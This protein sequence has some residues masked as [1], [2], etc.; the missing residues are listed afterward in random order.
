MTTLHNPYVGPRA[1]EP[2]DRAN[3]FGRDAEIRQLTDLVVAQRAVLLYARSGAGKTSLINAGLIPALERRRMTVL[4]VAR[5]GGGAPSAAPNPFVYNVLA[6][7]AAETVTPEAWLDLTLHEGL[8]PDA[9]LFAT[10]HSGVRL[11]ILDQFEELFTL[12]PDQRAAREAFFAQLQD[13]LDAYPHL[14]VLLAMREEYLAYLDTFSAML[15]DRL[16]TRFRLELLDPEAARLAIQAPAREQGVTFTDAAADQLVDDLRQMRTQR[17]DGTTTQHTGP[18][19]EPVQL[20]VVCRQIWA[21]TLGEND[22][23]TTIVASDL[24]AVG[25]VDKALATYYAQSV[26]RIAAETDV[27]ERAIRAWCEQHLITP[28]G[29]RGIVLRGTG[30]APA[31]VTRLEDAHLIRAEKR[32]GA[33]WYELAHDRLVGPVR[34]DNAAWFEANLSLLQRQAALWAEQ[35]RPAGLLLSDDVLVKATTWAEEHADEMLETEREF[36]AASRAEQERVKRERTQHRRIRWLAVGTTLLMLLACV[37]ACVTIWQ[38]QEVGEAILDAEYQSRISRAQALAALSQSHDDPTGSLNLMLAR[39]AA[40]TTWVTDTRIIERSF[41]TN[42][43]LTALNL[44]VNRAQQ[45]PWRMTIPWRVGHTDAVHAVAYSPDGNYI[46]SGSEDQTV[47]I[48]DAT[49]G[50]ELMQLTGHTG[51]IW[52]VAYSPD[53]TRIV[54]GGADQTVRIWDAAS[55][56]ELQ[57]L[58]GH[59]D[60][61]W[62]VAYSPDGERIVSGSADETVRV[63][64]AQ[65]GEEIQQ[66]TGHTDWVWAVAYSPDGERIVSGS[67]DETVRVWDAQ[68]GKEILE[69]IGHSGSVSTVGYSPDGTRIISG[70]GH[71]YEPENYATDDTVRIWDA[72]TGEELQQLTEKTGDLTAVTYSPDGIHILSG[73]WDGTAKI[74]D[75]ETG[76]KELELTHAGSVYAVVYSPDG[77]KIVSGSLDHTVRVWDAQTGAEVQS[78]VAA[79]PSTGHTDYVMAVAYSPDGERMVGGLSA[80]VKMGQCGSGIRKVAKDCSG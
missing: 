26:A 60:W 18:H 3:F 13:A 43:A 20:Q 49:S 45:L 74:W 4:P 27:R 23:R 48:W 14:G 29:L 77:T 42:E 70:G 46:V 38:I 41:V 67:A 63:W 52:S 61:V 53:G 80:G 51:G 25:D 22:T 76:E 5:V 24:E 34:E 66:L 8:A 37:L 78:G 28:Q 54:S 12:H 1:F 17:P 71:P 58:I 65:S 16:R 31:A 6:S 57:Q 79:A 32:A 56:E 7:V 15:P 9:P 39:E 44:A 2:E 40:L 72:Q 68:R 36:L 30:L 21:R 11:L 50:K 69:L 35:K 62:A 73:S 59:W 75:T 64:D 55:G 33:T 10:P 47:R 19:V